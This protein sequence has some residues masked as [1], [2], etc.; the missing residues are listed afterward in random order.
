M[1]HKYPARTMLLVCIL[2]INHKIHSSV[3]PKTPVFI[4]VHGTLKPP[5][6]YL[7]S[8]VNILNNQIDDSIYAKTIEYIRKDQKPL[9]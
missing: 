5:G 3:T 7:N 8:L 6:D 2:T 1:G 9:K 4:F